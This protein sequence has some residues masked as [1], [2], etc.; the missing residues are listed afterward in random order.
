[1]IWSHP[2][3]YR[4]KKWKVAV[5]IESNQHFDNKT[6]V[7]RTPFDDT[8]DLYSVSYAWMLPD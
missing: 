7:V 4:L 6:L 3:H 1:M 8:K 2:P 5:I